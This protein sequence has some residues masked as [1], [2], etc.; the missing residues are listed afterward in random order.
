MKKLICLLILACG[1]SS[2]ATAQTKIKTNGA[3]WLVGVLNLSAETRVS[4]HITINF[5][6]VYSPWERFF[7]KPLKIM[8]LIPEAR[9]YFRESYDGWYAGIYVAY[10]TFT[11]T[12]WDHWDLG[13]YQTGC[14]FAA[15]AVVGYAM[16][17]SDRW[18]MDFYVGGGY[19]QSEYMTY[20]PG[21]TVPWN[22]SAEWIPYKGGVAFAYK[23]NTGR[24]K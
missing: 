22:R 14:G 4:D 8:Q 9:Y 10:H 3:Y 19:Q 7:G 12:K 5:D 20:G 1:L 13:E 17:L 6:A 16:D 15:G 24:K 18:S 2:F 21:Y 11:M 23:I